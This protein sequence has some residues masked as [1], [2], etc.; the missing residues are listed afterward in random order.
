M[1]NEKNLRQDIRNLEV[2]DSVST[3]WKANI[4]EIK[5]R[6]LDDDM[7]NFIRW[8][9]IQK[10]MFVGNCAYID[11]EYKYIVEHPLWSK[12]WQFVIKEKHT[13]NPIPYDKNPATTGNTIHAVYHLARF[14]SD[15][16]HNLKDVNTVFEIGGG[17]GT[18]A[19]AFK[20]F[21]P[22]DYH[23]WDLPIFSLLQKWYLS[24]NNISTFCITDFA[25]LKRRLH[26]PPP[27]MMFI[28]T[29]AF[30]EMPI[31]ERKRF[32]P[33]IKKCKYILIA[34]QCEFDNVDNNKYFKEFTQTMANC[35]WQD[36][37]I[38]HLP[39]HKYLFGVNSYA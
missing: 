36:K 11:K 19:R 35:S 1:Y 30:S 10:T 15:M 13:G 14:I 6:I 5:E 21:T 2:D 31:E 38:E 12:E 34:Y 18:M 17:Y 24:Q 25:F 16:G 22:V 39:N 33:I 3:I 32:L 23:M 9:V 29:W 8:H 20:I 27:E 28:S 26:T 7:D 37:M 4:N